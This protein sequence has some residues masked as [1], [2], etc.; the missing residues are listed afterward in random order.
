MCIIIINKKLIYHTLHGYCFTNDYISEL[1]GMKYIFQDCFKLVEK[2][3]NENYY[4]C[5]GY[6]LSKC[7]DIPYKGLIKEFNVLCY[8]DNREKYYK[9][10]LHEYDEILKIL[11]DLFI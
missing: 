2:L 9:I 5:K 4:K 8:C 3:Y 11:T 1:K 6:N 10:T 7:I